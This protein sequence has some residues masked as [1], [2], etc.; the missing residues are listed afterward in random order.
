MNKTRVWRVVNNEWSKRFQT[1][2]TLL[3]GLASTFVPGAL[4]RATGQESRV[5]PYA[6]VLP[7]RALA[8]PRAYGSHP[9]FRVEWWYVTGIVE[10][11][12]APLG[13]QVTFFRARPARDTDNPS[14]FAPHQI[15]IAHAAI[16]DPARGRLLHQQRVARAGFGLAEALEKR[17]AVWIDDWRL[18][19]NESDYLVRVFAGDEFALDLVLRA[20]QPPMLNG[21]AGYSRKGP[22]PDSASYY[23]S[24]PQL[25]VHGRV[26]RQGRAESVAGKAWLDHEWSSSYLDERAQGWDWIGINLDDGGALMAFRIRARDGTSFWAGA[27]LRSPAGTVRTYAPAEVAFEA[28]RAWQSPRTSTRYPI[29][30]RVRIGEDVY[31]VAPLMDD[32]EQDAR[33]TAGTVYWEGAVHLLRGG[34]RVGAG[35]LELTGYWRKLKL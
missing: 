31:E 17:T 6:Q 11:S 15:L 14:R 33:S 28:K 13:F 12:Q 35:Y 2:R 8:F 3:C 19:Q 22:R 5:T 18:E 30:W 7:G 34:K 24:I 27:T 16:S 4:A 23:Y 29:A 10:A 26:V 1:R 25:A 32:Q 9:D 21:D 20:V